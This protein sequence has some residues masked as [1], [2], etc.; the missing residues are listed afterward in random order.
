VDERDQK[1][2][3][4]HVAMK[5]V[6]F[7]A[8][9]STARNRRLERCVPLQYCACFQDVFSVVF[10]TSPTSMFTVDETLF[11]F[12][13]LITIKTEKWR[14]LQNK[15]SF[16]LTEKYFGRRL[17]LIMRRG[18]Y[19]CFMLYF[20]PF[21]FSSLF[22]KSEPLCFTLCTKLLTKSV[23]WGGKRRKNPVSETLFLNIRQDDG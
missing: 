16:G 6:C 21:I 8:Y 17:S 18:L 11:L 23:S 7:C 3:V 5:S 2:Y 22:K 20:Y 14:E 15:I 10:N 4:D 1:Q 9:W 19:Y 13:K 12:A